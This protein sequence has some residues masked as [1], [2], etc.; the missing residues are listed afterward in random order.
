MTS[1]MWNRRTCKYLSDTSH[2]FAL[3]VQYFFIHSF[4]SQNLEILHPLILL[5]NYT[6]S[7]LF[8]KLKVHLKDELLKYAIF[9]VSKQ[10]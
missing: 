9:V 6:C 10:M 5:N 1:I 8:R 3:V 2:G 7:C 4:L